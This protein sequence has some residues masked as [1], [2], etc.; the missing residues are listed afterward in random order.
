M[1]EWLLTRSVRCR[2]LQL[3]LSCVGKA[4]GKCKELIIM[5]I[6]KR[7]ARV[8]PR[9]GRACHCR[10]RSVR[11]MESGDDDDGYL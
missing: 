8:S 3:Q 11:S 2:L 10:R 9:L 4:E 5:K 6:I 1:T 7:A